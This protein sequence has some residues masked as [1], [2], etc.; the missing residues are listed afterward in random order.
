MPG[1]EEMGAGD[2]CKDCDRRCCS[3]AVV[4]PEE[5]KRIIKAMRMG[6]LHRRR[7]F[8][9]RGRYYVMRGDVCHFLGKDGKCRIEDVKPLN[10]RIFP[11]VLSHQGKDA[12]WTVS[13]E[14]PA[15]KEV[16]PEFVEHAKEL[17][18]PLLE[19]HRKEGPLL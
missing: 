9:S 10:C 7:A 1:K 19:K 2:F 13:I 6:P 16:A 15:Y 4:L 18:E 8:E 12:E 5:R 17:G 14:C 3:R 11:V